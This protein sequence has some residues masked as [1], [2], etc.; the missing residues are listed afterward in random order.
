MNCFG[1]RANVF[2]FC[3]E[4]GVGTVVKQ[5]RTQTWTASG[6]CVLC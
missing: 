4:F 3:C 6:L 2:R 5:S 1:P